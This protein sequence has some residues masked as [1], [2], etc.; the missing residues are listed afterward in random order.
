MT[1][2]KI[3]LILFLFLTTATFLVAQDNS[4]GAVY[5][6]SNDA[7]GNSVLVFNR[8][9]DGSLTPGGSFPTS[10]LGTGAGLGSQGAVVLSRNNKLLFVVNPGS[11]ELSVFDVRE[12]GLVL[13]DTI[14]SGGRNPISVTVHGDLVYVLNAGGTV[15]DSDNISGFT[16]KCKGNLAPIPDSTR[17]LSAASTNPA[18]ISFNKDGSVL[19]VTEKDTNIIS[20]YTI[21]DDG[22]ATGPNSQPSAGMTPFGFAI[23]KRDQLIVS[24]AFGG[25]PDA[26]AVSSYDLANDGTIQVISPSVPT[27]ETA[28][29]WV[30]ITKNQKFAYVTNTGSASISGYQLD[31]DGTITL[32]DAD[33]V[34]ATTGAM[35][36]DMALSRNSKF[37]YTLNSGSN[38][39]S[40][41][42]VSNSD[43]SLTS[44][45]PDVTGIP[46]GATGLAAR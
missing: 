39:I 20:T 38:S 22:L 29:C 41:F 19:V 45:G 1:T 14:S 33:G 36:I 4:V 13:S 35:P 25:A 2:K 8:N 17:P 37:L 7:A 12:S 21:D 46:A 15:G 27:T 28:A 3:F 11:D 43:G 23:T 44:L 34:T 10:G 40:L 24:E 6:M 32:L 26:S 31:Q 30:V 18:Q 9:A 16:I 42:T 5:T